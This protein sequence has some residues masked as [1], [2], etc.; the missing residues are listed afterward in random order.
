MKNLIKLNKVTKVFTTEKSKEVVALKDISI[1]IKKNEFICIVGP[2]GCGKST[3]L[4]VISGLD[5]LTS[6]E[7]VF[8]DEIIKSRKDIGM[9]FQ[10]YSLYPWRTVI[11]NIAI[12]LE[13]NGISKSERKEISSKY[14]DMIGLSEFAHSYP[15][16]LSGG[17]QQRVAIAR[18]LANNPKLLLMDEPLGA[19]DAYT[20]LALQKEILRLFETNKSTVLFVTHSVDEAVFLADKIIIMSNKPGQIERIIDIDIEKPRDRTSIEFISMTS[21]ILSIMD[22]TRV[23]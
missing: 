6:G 2:S 4:R 1:D 22:R 18:A 11:D 15:Y 9:V 23:E 12:G 7:I 14:L 20:R 17:M 13:F 19:L 3:L 21:E 8:N 10:N 5:E 16:E